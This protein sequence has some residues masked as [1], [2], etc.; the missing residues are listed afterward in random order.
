[1]VD[2]L[3][4]KVPPGFAIGHSG[5]WNAPNA[6][7]AGAVAWYSVL[8]GLLPRPCL[9]LTRAALA[10]DEAEVRRIDAI[11]QPLWDLFKELSSLRVMYAAA[12]ILGLCRVEPPRPILPLPSAAYPRVAAALERLDADGQ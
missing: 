7:L 3:S 12:D 8:G 5:D 9:A 6:I 4:R 10:K 2:V 1:M 11:L